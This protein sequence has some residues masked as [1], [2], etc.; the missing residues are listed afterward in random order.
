MHVW[1]FAQA[2]GRLVGV[3]GA[4]LILISTAEATTHGTPA[5]GAATTGSDTSQET[6]AAEKAAAEK[7]AAEKAADKEAT[8]LCEL[9]N[10]NTFI[11][12]VIDTNPARKRDASFETTFVKSGGTSRLFVLDPEE[13]K[14]LTIYV[15]TAQGRISDYDDKD[16]PSDQD[17]KD[18]KKTDRAKD[19]NK[20]KIA[21]PS[22]PRKVIVRLFDRVENGWAIDLAIPEAERSFRGAFWRSFTYFV[23]ACPADGSKPKF[24]SGGKASFVA[25]AEARAS[26]GL[27]SFV[28][29]IVLVGAF[30]LL[31]AYGHR[32][33][34]R[35]FAAA[36][37]LSSSD[38]LTL[39]PIKLTAGLTG[40]GSISNLQTFVFS[41][42]VLFLLTYIVLR[43][44]VL[45]GLSENVIWL[46]GIVG[47][48]AVGARIVAGAREKLTPLN[49][50]WA[51]KRDWLR[52]QTT[53]TSLITRD[54]ELSVSRFQ[55]IAFT[56]VVAI[57]LLIN[58]FTDL[59]TF[60]IPASLLGLL[61]ASQAIYL[62][63]KSVQPPVAGDEEIE[64]L[65]ALL[66]EARELEEALVK[67]APKA[68]T[69]DAFKDELGD[70]T[71]P[72]VDYTKGL[73]EA[74]N[75]FAQIFETELPTKGIYGL[76]FGSREGSE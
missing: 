67:A 57:A 46:L 52:Y 43:T 63:G 49:L 42:I 58:G 13:T 26:Q 70:D 24:N 19:L 39:N 23:M 48:G 7:A 16:H 55:S 12:D 45:S 61:G 11:K 28:L 31:V 35:K 62:G 53:S 22:Y 3:V 29:A 1:H 40:R 32:A 66:K 18:L 17:S 9:G 74:A 27:T 71:K 76:E 69:L 25:V 10:L 21:K 68:R 50:R 41:L 73:N 44:G 47:G 5:P 59:E 4:L 65:N 30:Y 56:S 54:R 64:G 72:L 33:S 38:A 14:G 37:G 36:M 2:A 51:L 15:V 20:P 75:R 34:G 60:T 6:S 8:P